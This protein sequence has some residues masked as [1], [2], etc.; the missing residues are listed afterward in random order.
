MEWVQIALKNGTAILGICHGAQLL[1][2]TCDG[3]LVYGEGNEKVDKGLTGLSLTKEGRKD[4][5][6]SQVA[7]ESQVMQ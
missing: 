2:Y 1:A 5:V 4:P 7:P 6:L 3:R